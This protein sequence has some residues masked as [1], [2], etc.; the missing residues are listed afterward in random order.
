MS[1][2]VMPWGIHHMIVMIDF[3]NDILVEAA[4]IGSYLVSA[5]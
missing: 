1:A 5:P 3:L 2:K 4:L